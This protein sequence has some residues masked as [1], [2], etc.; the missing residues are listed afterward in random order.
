MNITN[1]SYPTR[2]QRIMNDLITDTIQT[3]LQNETT[4]TVAKGAV[5]RKKAAMT[6][7]KK[8]FKKVVF[9]RKRV[10]KKK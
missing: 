5:N 4:K 9:K 7:D 10:L 6:Q 1:T 3:K 2:N 8:K